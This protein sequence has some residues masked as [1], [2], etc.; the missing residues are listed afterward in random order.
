MKG[1]SQ[2]RPSREHHRCIQGVSWGK[3]SREHHGGG[4]LQRAPQGGLQRAPQG[5]P[6]EST[7]GGASRE[8]HRREGAPD[9]NITGG[10]SREDHRGALQRAPEGRAS[11]EHNEG[12]IPGEHYPWKTSRDTTGKTFQTE[13][14]LRKPG[15]LRQ[16]KAKAESEEGL[17]GGRP[18][19]ACGPSG[20]TRRLFLL[21]TAGMQ[22]LRLGGRGCLRGGVK[23]G[24]GY[25]GDVHSS[26]LRPAELCPTS[27]CES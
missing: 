1:G 3:A 17:N 21:G 10:T 15:L 2:R 26:C 19:L 8:H 5:G 6:P 13:K 22:A 24:L 27:S 20:P 18:L 16:E 25:A 14:V 7:T 4:E 12:E 23:E 9:N 11:R